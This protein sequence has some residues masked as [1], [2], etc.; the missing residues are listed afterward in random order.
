M[1]V[2]GKLVFT[3]FATFC[4]FSSLFQVFGQIVLK[5]VILIIFGP[6]GPKCVSFDTFGSMWNLEPKCTLPVA[7]PAVGALPPNEHS[8]GGNATPEE[9]CEEHRTFDGGTSF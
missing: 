2:D 9:G 4:R 7:L 1:E 5:L 3:T 6:F 8:M